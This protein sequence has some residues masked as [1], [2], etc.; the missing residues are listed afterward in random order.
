MICSLSIFLA[1]ICCAGATNMRIDRRLF[2]AASAGA[3]L[4]PA[5]AVGP[6]ARSTSAKNAGVNTIL[7]YHP[8]AER[9]LKELA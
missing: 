9:A 6:V 1:D 3:L 8:G 2:A 5:D 4:M 7:P